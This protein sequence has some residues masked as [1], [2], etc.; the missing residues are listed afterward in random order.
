MKGDRIYTDYLR[1]IL[2]NA[3]KAQEF[4]GD[5]GFEAF[6][7]DDKTVFAVTRALEIIGEAAKNVPDKVRRRYPD[8]PWRDMSGMRDKITHAYFGVDLR[9]V[10]ETVRT[11]L[12]SLRD[13]VI[14]ALRDVESGDPQ[15]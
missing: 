6:R 15:R 3:E 1:D 9:R 11:S 2:D 12:P 13:A 10:S 14:R 5:M 4:L 8:V 7:T